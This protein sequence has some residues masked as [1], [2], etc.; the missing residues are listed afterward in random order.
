MS[1]HRHHNDRDYD[2]WDYVTDGLGLLVIVLGIA[3]T[4]LAL[5]PVYS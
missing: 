3:T 1:H 4:I 2:R 5:T